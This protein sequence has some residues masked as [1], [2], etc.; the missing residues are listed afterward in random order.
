M[1]CYQRQGGVQ[2]RR[3]C[4][5]LV[6]VPLSPSLGGIT[7]DR[8]Q[9][10]GCRPGLPGRLEAFGFLGHSDITSG[11]SLDRSRGGAP[12]RPGR[13]T[14]APELGCRP[15]RRASRSCEMG[16]LDL[17]LVPGYPGG[18]GPLRLEHREGAVAGVAVAVEA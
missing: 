4:H 14:A 9:R 13:P 10:I 16:A 3:M 5:E 11:A 7:E 18:D 12:S 2:L 1:L 8:E 6:D 15:E 17:H